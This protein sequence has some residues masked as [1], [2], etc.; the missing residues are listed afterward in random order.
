MAVGGSPVGSPVGARPTWPLS[1]GAQSAAA[2]TIAYG[3]ESPGNDS[4]SPT[5]DLQVAGGVGHPH[6]GKKA[7][8]QSSGSGGL[9]GPYSSSH[10]GKART[11][12][13]RGRAAPISGTRLP[14]LDEG[15]EPLEDVPQRTSEEVRLLRDELASLGQQLQSA[16]LG[17]TQRQHDFERSES[18]LQGEVG[19][20]H[21]AAQVSALACAAACG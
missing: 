4:M 18:I 10:Y 8:T 19:D 21:M 6:P 11:D 16:H 5:P 17:L 20:A 2:S 3:H 14:T 15:G 13:R 7:S 9:A 1:P 12:H